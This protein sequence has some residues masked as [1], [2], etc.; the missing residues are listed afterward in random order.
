MACLEYLRLMINII[1]SGK[2]LMEMFWGV[3]L[4]VDNRDIVLYVIVH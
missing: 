4:A 3:F 2:I 1:K